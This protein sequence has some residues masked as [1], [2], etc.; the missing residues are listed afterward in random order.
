[1]DVY[2]ACKLSTVCQAAF[3]DKW[4]SVYLATYD[5]SVNENTVTYMRKTRGNYKFKHCTW[6]QVLKV[7]E[8]WKPVAPKKNIGNS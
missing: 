5:P 3:F 1:M 8:K 4:G 7:G 6:S 2:T